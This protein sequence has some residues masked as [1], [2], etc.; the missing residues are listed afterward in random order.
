MTVHDFGMT[1]DRTLLLG[2]TS[3]ALALCVP[4]IDG[5]VCGT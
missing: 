2:P 4:S 1:L 3:T 5:T